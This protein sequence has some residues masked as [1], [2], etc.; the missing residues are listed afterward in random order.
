MFLELKI[1]S[2]PAILGKVCISYG[3]LHNFPSPF[4][5]GSPSCETEQVRINLLTKFGAN[6]AIFWQIAP[7]KLH[8][9]NIA[10]FTLRIFSNY[11]T[12]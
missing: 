12:S 1:A 3:V 9:I 11:I 2:P 4:G 5:S 10:L 7:P 6:S 8:P